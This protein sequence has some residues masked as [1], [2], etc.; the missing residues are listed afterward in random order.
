MTKNTKLGTLDVLTVLED[1]TAVRTASAAGKVGGSD[2]IYNA[3]EG[4]MDARAIV[5]VLEVDSTATGYKIQIQGSTSATF[6]DDIVN[7]AT[8]ELGPAAKLVGD[9]DMLEG[10]Y[11]LPFVNVTN[12]VIRPYLRVYLDKEEGGSASKGVKYSCHLVP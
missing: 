9:K 3:G 5:N 2:K 6:T 12:N 7:L 11:E 8:L 4:R 1:G 10:Q